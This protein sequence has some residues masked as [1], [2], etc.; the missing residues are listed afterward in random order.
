MLK[1]LIVFCSFSLLVGCAST[2]EYSSANPQNQ[3]IKAI[4]IPPGTS[5][6]KI[7][8]YYPVPVAPKDQQVTQPSLVPPGAKKI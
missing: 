3:T 1:V 5:T 6:S 2:D 4:S 8:D 7:K